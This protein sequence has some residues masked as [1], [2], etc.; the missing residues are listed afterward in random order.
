MK[1][2][3]LLLAIALPSVLALV[4]LGYR[5]FGTYAL[6]NYQ[7]ELRAKGEK[8]TLSELAGSLTPCLPDSSLALSN[9]FAKLGPPPAYITNLNLM[10][11]VSLGRA[12]V[13]WRQPLP[14]WS[15]T[16]ET[17]AASWP[18]LSN[19]LGQKAG[20]LADLR[21]ALKQPPPNAGPRTNILF[22]TGGLSV[23]IQ[24]AAGWLACAA[25]ADLHDAHS[26]QALA[27]LQA[28]ASLANLYREDYSLYTAMTRVNVAQVALDLTWEALQSTDWNNDQL[29]ALQKS[30]Q[31]IDLL[32][33]LERAFE[34]ER[35]CG[36]ETLKRWMAENKDEPQEDSSLAAWSAGP[37]SEAFVKRIW[38]ET[39]APNDLRF[40]IGYWQGKIKLV[41]DLRANHSLRQVLAPWQK[42][43]D[44]LDKK[45][46]PPFRFLYPVSLVSIPNP[47]RALLQTLHVETERRL[48]LT[49]IALSRYQRLHGRPPAS[50]DALLPDVLSSPVL[51]CMSGRLL[52][53]QANGD[54]TFNL[55]S[56]GNDGTD[57]GGDSSPAVPGGKLGLWEGRDAVWPVAVP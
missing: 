8:V 12:R 27:N 30:W 14:P 6:Q 21:V 23:A 24:Y 7:T 55:Y 22:Q 4:G 17:S 26:D 9:V 13:A 2:R 41:R 45:S 5:L 37:V 35:L 56:V 10:R 11:F 25:L 50:L 42:L 54:R 1:K 38:L 44:G 48:A 51:D 28:L 57:N 52:C 36:V 40:G 43:D 34:G 15:S 16:C 53:Y 31:S 3:R 18:G 39:V 20:P 33:G 19:C 46:H 32:E 49:A 47:K 29:L